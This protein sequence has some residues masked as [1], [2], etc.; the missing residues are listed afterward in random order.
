[1]RRI[2]GSRTVLLRVL[3][4]TFAL[5]LMGCVEP[6]SADSTSA[7]ADGPPAPRAERP[8]GQPVLGWT[9]ESFTLPRN[10]RVVGTIEAREVV[11]LASHASGPLTHVAGEPG[12]RVREGDRVLAVDRAE[13]RGELARAQAQLRLLEQQMARQRELVEAGA[14]PRSQ[15]D[16]LGD[17]RDVAAA[18][19]AL[20]TTR[21][22]LAETRAPL[23]GTVVERLAEPGSWV[24]AH[25][26]VLRVAD[27]DDL[28]VRVPL[29]E[30]DVPWLAEDFD[31]TV[32]VDAFPEANARASLHRISP[33]A[34]G[35]SRQVDVFF[36][37]ET[38][39]APVRLAPGQLVRMTLALDLQPRMLIPEQ[40]LLASPPDAPF[41]FAIVDH[42]L[43]Q[44]SVTTGVR[45]R[46]WVEVVEGLTP[47][48]TIVAMN[49]MTLRESQTVWIAEEQEAPAEAR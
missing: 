5:L 1:M 29:S 7:E 10:V 18:E 21:V 8:A 15:L 47:G 38:D 49:P 6:A 41:V 25:Q 27:L 30:R 40:A 19:V 48:D 3:L 39:D 12:D 23:T 34:S 13:A 44:R 14:A 26:P 16:A 28:V 17:E 9:V 20:Y 43:S 35:A 24:Q 42:Q 33:S 46:G 36:R 2:P 4:A 32:E 37:L 22:Q 11:T 31:T 45:R